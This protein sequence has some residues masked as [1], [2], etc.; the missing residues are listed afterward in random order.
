MCETLNEYTEPYPIL[1]KVLDSKL[2]ENLD[3]EPKKNLHQELPRLNSKNQHYL[4]AQIGHLDQ[5]NFLF[6]SFNKHRMDC[7]IQIVISEIRD[8]LPYACIVKAWPRMYS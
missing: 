2:E 6:S 3:V 1:S 4:R 8:V 7:N 5:K